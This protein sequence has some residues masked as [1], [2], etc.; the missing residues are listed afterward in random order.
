M[1]AGGR[2][3]Q[4]AVA[5]DEGGYDPLTPTLSRR[6]R[7]SVKQPPGYFYGMYAV[8]F[9]C[10]NKCHSGQT[11]VAPLLACSDSQFRNS[12]SGSG[13]QNRKP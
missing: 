5:E 4:G 6:E 9:R 13:L 8:V 12:L 2:A 11:E 10:L 1:D 7:E 3:T